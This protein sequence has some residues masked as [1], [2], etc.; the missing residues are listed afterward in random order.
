MWPVNANGGKELLYGLE[1]RVLDVESELGNMGETMSMT[2]K[3]FVPKMT[4]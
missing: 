2:I 3:E 1:P 4:L